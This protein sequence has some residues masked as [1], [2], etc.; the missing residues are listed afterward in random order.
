M[1][2]VC[3]SKMK[4]WFQFIINQF[5]AVSSRS[6]LL[7]RCCCLPC[8]HRRKCTQGRI[9]IFKKCPDH[10]TQKSVKWG[11]NAEDI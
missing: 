11:S 5:A 4:D 2:A 3:S 8:N 7:S 9:E 6:L 1:N 10:F